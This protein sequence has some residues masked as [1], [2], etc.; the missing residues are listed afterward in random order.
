VFFFSSSYFLGH[1]HIRVLLT[2]NNRED[3]VHIRSITGIKCNRLIRLKMVQFP[4]L[5]KA[6]LLGFGREIICTMG[7]QDSGGSQ[8]GIAGPRTIS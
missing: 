1:F 2:L 6:L 8:K 5:R 3:G 7:H 4:S